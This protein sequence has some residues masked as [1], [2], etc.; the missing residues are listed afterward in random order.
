MQKLLIVLLTI[1]ISLLTSAVILKAQSS[2]EPTAIQETETINLEHFDSI[3]SDMVF[4]VEVRKSNEEKVVIKSN[5]LRLVEANVK[6][7]V[8]HIGYKKNSSLQNPDTRIIIY[9]KNIKSVTARTA[10]VIKIKDDFDIQRFSAET[11]GRIFGNSKAATVAIDTQTN[12]FFLGTVNTGNLQINADLG[13]SVDIQGNIG[14]AKI[15]SGGASKITAVKA[16]ISEAV[17]TAEAAS[18]V[19]LSVSKELTASATSAAKIRY[20][21]LSP[22]K[23]SAKRDSAGT[24]DML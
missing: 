22:I 6:N 24:I 9:A 3:I 23:F 13:S 8:L 4:N 5:Y 16:K 1:I 19:T 15:K 7:N 2:P 10:S 21:T 12:G 11:G 20:K 17:V 14:F 18:T